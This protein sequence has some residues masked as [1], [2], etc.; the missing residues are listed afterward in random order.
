M[1]KSVLLSIVISQLLF[2]AFLPVFL[3]LTDYLH[4]IMLAVVWVCILLMTFFFV[5]LITKRTIQFS[6]RMLHSF[7]TL[8][9][10]GLVTLLFFRPNNQIYET[11][12]LVPMETIQFFLSE[13]VNFLV[14]FYN[15]AANVGL[16]VPFGV[17]YCF[18][19]RKRSWSKLLLITIGAISTIEILQFLTKRGTLDIDD[20]I[21]NVL[22]VFIGFFLYPIVKK[23]I[24]I[25]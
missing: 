25:I 4:P 10:A 7:I 6:R 9:S 24:K 18:I 21:L 2:F 16:F 19:V 15:L 17:Y 22:G 5:L 12:N 14:A 23:V 11:V 1:K 3:K 13:E 8:Y 20:L